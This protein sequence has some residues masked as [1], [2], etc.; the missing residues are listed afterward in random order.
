LIVLAPLLTVSAFS[1]AAA[2][3]Q[4]ELKLIIRYSSFAIRYSPFIIRY[5]M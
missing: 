5:S 4:P 1:P 2:D 3:L